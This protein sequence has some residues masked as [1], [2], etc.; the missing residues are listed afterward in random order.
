[1]K[2]LLVCILMIVTT[3][4][5]ASE[6]DLSRNVQEDGLIKI[7][8][9]RGEIS[10]EGWSEARVQVKGDL[11][12]LAEG[13]RFEV[14]DGVTEIEVEMPGRNVSWGDGSDLIIYV[15]TLSRVAVKAVA[16]DIEVSDVFGGMQLRS[17]SG[18]ITLENGRERISLKTVSGSIS[19]TKTTGKLQANSASGDIEVA[20][21]E[22]DIG[23][24]TLSG[25]IEIEARSVRHLTGASISGDVTVEAVFEQDVTAKLTSVSGSIS[26][27]LDEPLDF[28]FQANSN[29]GNIGNRLSAD[30]VVK[31]YGMRSL[32]GRVGNG[33]GSLTVRSVS[34]EIDLEGG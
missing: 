11:D 10:I 8:I 23:I 33:A 29:S 27:S 22:G 20:A 25:D 7:E 15:P 12:E 26:V 14:R 34:G 9:L 30:E 18:D 13:L 32:Q 3:V 24:E 16:T 1:M 17:I 21:H 4:L 28:V 31:E 6:I 2:F 5:E 19:A